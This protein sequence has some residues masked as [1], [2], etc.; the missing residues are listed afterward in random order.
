V[1]EH[2]ERDELCELVC[3]AHGVWSYSEDRAGYYVLELSSAQLRRIADALQAATDERPQW[4]CDWPPT[5]RAGVL[6]ACERAPGYYTRG[7]TPALFVDGFGFPR[8]RHIE[9]PDGLLVEEVDR[10]GNRRFA[11][12]RRQR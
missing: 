6:I 5:A 12:V 4:A 11:V 9:P 2:R 10:R 1:S 3:G 7:G 8:S